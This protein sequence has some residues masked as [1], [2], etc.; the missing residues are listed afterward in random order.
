MKIIMEAIEKLY[1][2]ID[3][4]E[5]YASKAHHLRHEHK[6]LADAYIKS[7]EAHIEIFKTLHETVVKLIA[8]QKEKGKMPT[9]EMQSIYDHE[10]QRLVSEFSKAKWLVEEYKKA[11]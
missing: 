11:Y 3:E 4:V 1:D 9:P 10:H 6:M 7:A 5:Y 8:E 2:V